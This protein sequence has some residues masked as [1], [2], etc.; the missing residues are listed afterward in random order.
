MADRKVFLFA[1]PCNTD[2]VI[3]PFPQSHEN[4]AYT[5]KYA[6]RKHRPTASRYVGQIQT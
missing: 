4:G 5:I 3:P 2:T 6:L 1:L